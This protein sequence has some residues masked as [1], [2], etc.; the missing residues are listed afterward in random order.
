V[1]VD[2]LFLDDVAELQSSSSEDGEEGSSSL[3]GALLLIARE[4]V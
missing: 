4:A 1:L 2:G 3:G